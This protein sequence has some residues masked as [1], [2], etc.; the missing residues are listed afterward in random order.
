MKVVGVPLAAL[1]LCTGCSS[2]QE[3]RCAFSDTYTLNQGV[4]F[5]V[6]QSDL[7]VLAPASMFRM[8]HYPPDNDPEGEQT[9][10]TAMPACADATLIDVSDI[11]AAIAHVD[12]QAAFAQ[13]DLPFYG[14]RGLADAP[15]STFTRADQRGFHVAYPCVDPQATTCSRMPPGVAALDALLHDLIAQQIRDPSCTGIQPAL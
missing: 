10:A 11:E 7:V 13:T 5:P 4:P 2:G 6:A 15:G 14:E 9:C 8:Q 1:L 3:V 12:V